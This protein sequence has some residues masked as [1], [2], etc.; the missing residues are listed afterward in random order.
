VRIAIVDSSPLINLTHLGLADRLSLSFDRIY[1]P[2]AVQREVNRKARFRYRLNKL[3][4][5]G[6][7]MKCG[8]ADETNVSLLR[9]ELHEGEA[10]ALIQAQ[11]KSA[12]FFVGDEKRAREIAEKMGLTAVGT[13]R[14]LARLNQDGLAAEP[15]SLVRKLRR[16]LRF[17]ISDRVVEEAI[18][19]ATEP[20]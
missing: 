17:R 6:F 13:V 7:F 3:Y 11:E 14:I 9:V 12:M 16:D 8:V 4:Q 15:K 18:A 19:I 5:T 20:I 10:E 2:R 1:V